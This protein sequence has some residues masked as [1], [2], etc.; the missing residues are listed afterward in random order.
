MTVPFRSRHLQRTTATLPWQPVDQYGEPAN[1]GTV[2][3]GVV[4]S[5]GTEVIAAGTATS[6]SSAEQRTIALTA[7]QTAQVD[8]L[9]ATWKVS[10]TTVAVTEHDIVGGFLFSI[11]DA[12]GIEKSTSDKSRDPDLP[13]YAARDV[14]EWQIENFCSRAFVPRFH[15]ERINCIPGGR[16]LMLSFPNLRVVRWA[17]QISGATSTALTAGELAEIPASD[18]WF[19]DRLTSSWSCGVDVTIGYEHGLLSPPADLRRAAIKLFRHNLNMARSS[20]RDGAVSVTDPNGVSYQLGRVGTE[21]RPTGID[22]VDEVLR[23]YDMTT[24]GMA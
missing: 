4:N 8:T 22:D 9:T 5:A 12:R 2:T 6:G 23:R 15:S 16:R 3:V 7:A 10:G 17:N 14:T 1:P 13:A 20:H 19:A 21:R 24:P 11:A 18:G